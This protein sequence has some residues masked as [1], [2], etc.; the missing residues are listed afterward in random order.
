MLHDA[1][2]VFGSYGDILGDIFVRIC[3][4]ANIFQ[5]LVSHFKKFVLLFFT[6]FIVYYFNCHQVII[7]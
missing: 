6:L 4:A 7:L 2:L 1:F 5:V 3:H